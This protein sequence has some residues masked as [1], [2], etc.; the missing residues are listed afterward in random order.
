MR[1]IVKEHIEGR[2]LPLVLA[3]MGGAGHGR[4]NSIEAIKATL[5]YGPDIIEVDVRKSK[6]GVLYCHHGS[7]PFGIALA[8]FFRLMTFKRIKRIAGERNTLEEVLNAIPNDTTVFLD[9]KDRRIRPEELQQLLRERKSVWLGIY[10]YK[11][12]KELRSVLGEQYVYVLNKVPLLKIVPDSMDMTDLQLFSWQRHT[13]VIS[14]RGGVSLL[15]HTLRWA[16]A[17]AGI[18]E[19][20]MKRTHVV[21][22]A[23]YYNDLSKT[24][25]TKEQ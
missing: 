19:T 15:R 13:G 3:H 20:L 12:L 4:E 1:Q 8:Q 22:I 6:D 23:R 25:R 18:S 16:L 11:H 21:S 10:S 2:E 7:I 9:V 24:H 5:P 17:A 14:N